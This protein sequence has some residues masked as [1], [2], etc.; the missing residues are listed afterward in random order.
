MDLTR[1]AR[2]RRVV[3]FVLNGVN[4]QRIEAPCEH[5]EKTPPHTDEWAQAWLGFVAKAAK[6]D[7]P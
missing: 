2:E 1:R 7:A 5:V 3:A 6:T 4:V